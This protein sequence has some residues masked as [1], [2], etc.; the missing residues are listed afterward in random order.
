ML[1]RPRRRRPT[2]NTSTRRAA[3]SAARSTTST[4][5]TSS[6]SRRHH[7]D[8]PA[9]RAGS[10]ARHLQQR[11]HEHRARDPVL[12]QPSPGAAT[13]PRY[14]VSK[15]ATERGKHPWSMG[16]LLSF[17]GEGAIYGC[18]H[19]LAPAEDGVFLRELGLRQGHAQRAGRRGLGGKA[20]I[21][22]TQAYQIAE[23]RC[24][25]AEMARL[26]STGADTLTPFAT[27][28]FVSSSASACSRSAGTRM[29][30]VTSV[31]I[32]PGT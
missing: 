2:S 1:G 30:S 11:R 22:G 29:F 4:S 12:Y 10:G 5:T 19:C 27:P 32:S 9:R 3:S 31:S 15:L 24:R 25:L 20:K 26:K 21:V 16:Y 23:L 8:A 6:T 13:L 18:L 7:A 17:A 28:Q 14:G